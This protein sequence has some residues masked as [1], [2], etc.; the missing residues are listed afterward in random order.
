[1]ETLVLSYG[2]TWEL[3]GSALDELLRT[4]R[5][6]PAET[7][8]VARYLE[9]G[10]TV[11]DAGAHHGYYTLLASRCVG[12]T[13]QV[14][15]IEPSPRERLRLVRHLHKNH[16][17]NVVLLPWALGDREETATLHLVDGSED[18]CNSLRL[19]AGVQATTPVDV[20]VRRL[21][22]VIPGPVDFVKLDVE[23][24]ERAAL[25]GALRLVDTAPRPVWLIEIS[26]T[27]TAPWGYPAKDILDLLH[28][29]RYRWFTFAAEG[30]LT[31]RDPAARNPEGNL[32]ALPEE[33]LT[34]LLPRLL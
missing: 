12:L 17:Q 18:F 20:A 24:A 34:T 15:A 2:A 28:A 32:V 10:M 26:E 9:P 27:R 21:D 8:F 3:A 4:Q 16:C 25:G 6:E 31:A 5:F 22:A 33:R 11:V 14:F 7:L 19:P 1:M 30:R 23:G 29:H 13:G